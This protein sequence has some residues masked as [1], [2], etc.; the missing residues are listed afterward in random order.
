MKSS[1]PTW[2]LPASPAAAR[3]DRHGRV[4]RIGFAFRSWAGRAWATIGPGPEAGRGA[5]WGC[6]GTAAIAAFIEAMYLNLGWGLW[7]DFAFCLFAS[8][9]IILMGSLLIRVLLFLI[10]KLPR[11]ATALMVGSCLIIVLVLPE[12]FGPPVAITIGLLEGLWGVAIATLLLGSFRKAA[13]AKKVITVTLLVLGVVANAELFTFFR[14]DGTLDGITAY[15]PKRIDVQQVSAPNPASPGA[16]NIKTLTYGSGT[17]RTRLE[18]GPAAALKTRTVDASKFFRD[19]HGWKRAV[20]RRYWGFDADK[21]PL[22]AHV[23]YP[24]GAGPF[25]LVLIVHGNHAMTEPSELGYAYL[26]ELLASR[27][28]I[29][30][31]ID[32]NFLNS[33]LFHRLP[34]DQPVRAW[35]LLEHLKLWR[36]WKDAPGNPFC[37]KVDFEH[38]AVIGHSRGGEAAATAA[39]F[40]RLSYYPED[41]TIR[42]DYGFS[43]RSVVGIAPD[44]GHYRPTGEHR[45]LQD[46]SYLI[47]QG[48]WDAD[49]ASFRGSR[50]YDY[51]RYTHPGPSFKSELWIYRANHGQFNTVWGRKDAWGPLAWFLNVKPLMSG[52]DQRRV[53]KVYIAAFL[54][55]TLRDRREYIPLFR[56][57][58]AGRKWLPEQVYLSRFE[59]ASYQTVAAFN[60]DP[61]LTTTTLPGG[62][63]SAEGFATWR[64]GRIPL[65]QGQRDYNGLFLGW[66]R[67]SGQAAPWYQIELPGTV[68]LTPKS[69][70]DLSV[71]PLDEDLPRLDSKEG[72]RSRETPDFTIELETARGEIARQP[73]S[74][75]GSIAP[76][77]NVRLTKLALLDAMKEGKATETVLQSVTAPLSAFGID[78][79]GV[80]KIRFRFDRTRQGAILISRIS[81]GQAPGDLSSLRDRIHK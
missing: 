45:T 4:R 5:A 73:V 11:S 22:N 74:L 13:L 42:F 27:G 60:E 18:Y 57:P 28:F 56:H 52:D 80:K 79:T 70:L 16:F 43:I 69:V 3:S 38:I 8:A 49:V 68:L 50:Q 21:L 10:G 9:L 31:S 36:D 23:W 78:P 35:L 48:G 76:P 6:L 37:G 41:A 67:G 71:A 7:F 47:M 25:P 2:E 62:R 30:A 15:Q 17:D 53:A 59:D 63:A 26:G 65:R 24:E 20:R 58:Q 40:N 12:D 55:A 32:E 14:N 66:N 19:F 34:G 77:L 81:V 39:L 72:I 29:V 64:E 46:V 33:G 54:E 75:F 51:V 44:D 61:D 1:Q